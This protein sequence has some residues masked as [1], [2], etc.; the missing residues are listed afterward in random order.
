MASRFTSKTAVIK[1]YDN[2]PTTRLEVVAGPGQGDFTCSNLFV[3]GNT[4]K[5][6]ARDRG[7]HDG[8]VEG[9]D[10]TQEWS[11]TLEQVNEALTHVSNSRVM[12]FLRK[13]GSFSSAISMDDDEWAFGVEITMT[14]G[15]VTTVIDLP[16]SIGMGDF[17]EGKETNTFSV[18]GTN[19]V[20]P[21]VT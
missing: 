8:F 16:K 6:E 17:T 11:L 20:A 18:S 21:D 13:T 2:T 12:D 5:I 10:L 19:V 15:A 14:K 9:D 4:E 1:F 3:E 7:T